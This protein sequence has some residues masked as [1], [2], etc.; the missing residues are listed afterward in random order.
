MEKE[1]LAS[2]VESVNLSLVYGRVD[3]KYTAL[4][5]PISVRIQINL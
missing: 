5:F 4:L 3:R 2:A 1:V